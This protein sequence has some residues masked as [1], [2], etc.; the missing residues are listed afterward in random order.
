VIGPDAGPDARDTSI[1]VIP[2]ARDTS[3]EVIPDA[4][5]TSGEVILGAPLDTSIEAIPD[6]PPDLA[7]P[8]S[9][10]ETSPDTQDA[11]PGGGTCTIGNV[12]SAKVWSTNAKLSDRYGLAVA[13]DGSRWATG[14]LY[15]ANV[16]LGTGT[17]LPSCGGGCAQYSDA[18]LARLDPSSGR[19]TQAF[20]FGDA[21]DSEQV[22]QSVA[23]APSGN[24]VV[25]GNYS[26][27]IDFTLLALQG[28]GSAVDNV[29]FLAA[30]S[31][32]AGSPMGY[33]VLAD[34]AA[35]IAAGGPYIVPIKARNVDVGDG[36]LYAAA[37]GHLPAP[38]N[39]DVI[40][41]CGYAR[42]GLSVYSGTSTSNTGAITG[43]P[44]TYDPLNDGLD[45]V[46]FVIDA[47]TGDV[48][49]GQQFGHAGDQVCKSIGMDASGNVFIAG[50]W[51]GVLDFGNGHALTGSGGSV[52]PAMAL[53]YVAKFDATG[54]CQAAQTWGSSGSSAVNGLA[55][56]ASG[57]VYIAGNLGG[58]NNNPF[59]FVD[60]PIKNRGGTD[61]F[62]AKLDSSLVA[63]WAKSFGD[64]ANKQS[65][66]AIGVTSAGN[67][68]IGGTTFTGSLEGLGLVSLKTT[69]S[70]AFLAQLSG[71]DGSVISSAGGS[72][73][74]AYS[75]G[76]GEVQG[77]QQIFAISVAPT[78]AQADSI[79]IGGNFTRTM[80]LG[81]TTLLSPATNACNA[82]ADCP[83]TNNA[84]CSS[85]FC[86]SPTVP[87][88]T[89]AC[90]KDKD[91]DNSGTC[92]DAFC[93]GG[94]VRSFIS[95][96]GP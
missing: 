1:D 85:G 42:R 80:A 44:P 36:A 89:V 94:K 30:N 78:G 32:S 49:W 90:T 18:F 29:D 39:K 45:I 65:A 87:T 79:L 55:V 27:E 51:N 74:C 4:L 35:S 91:C 16:D 2:D 56:D 77:D 48:I 83:T 6:S 38:S 43:T 13:P 34:G 23:V 57:N 9:P 47:L 73:N 61:A 25:M 70:E 59:N 19:A 54:V 8:D 64:V 22:A 82:N 15:G 33:Y 93:V 63:Q 46:V 26:G 40:A 28:D 92:L 53:P 95:R 21:A 68:L 17:L 20:T 71:A 11:P 50:V 52:N 67:V 37:G 76:G 10:P 60:P 3:I 41:I 66:Y 88:G 81:S 75:Y 5:D 69:G 58:A 7:P 96:L 86:V 72:G 62:A 24:V 14:V 12:T 84:T 31:K